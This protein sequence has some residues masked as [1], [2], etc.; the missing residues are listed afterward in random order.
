MGIF[1]D[2][3]FDCAIDKGLNFYSGV[4]TSIDTCVIQLVLFCAFL[5]GTLDSLMVSRQH[6]SSCLF[7]VLV[8]L[9]HC[10]LATSIVWFGCS[11]QR[12]SDGSGSGQVFNILPSH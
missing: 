3:S 11:S 5:L 8:L 9:Q 2:E 1:S 6:L 7:L 10:G 4:L 12:S